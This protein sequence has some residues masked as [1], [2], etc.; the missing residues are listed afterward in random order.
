MAE[1][2]VIS[3]ILK[4]VDAMSADLK[5]VQDQLGR[6]EGTVKKLDQTTG[7]AGGSFDSLSAAIITVNQTLDLMTRAVG[8]VAGA[9]NQIVAEAADAELKTLVLLQFS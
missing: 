7:K 4:S 3:V 1:E 6:V 2:N 5:K 9:F 8:F